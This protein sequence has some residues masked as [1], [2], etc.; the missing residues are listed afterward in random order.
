MNKDKQGYVN[1]Q[2]ILYDIIAVIIILSKKAL[3]WHCV[4]EVSTVS[5]KLTQAL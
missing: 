1:L 2:L 4:E 3:K 5:I